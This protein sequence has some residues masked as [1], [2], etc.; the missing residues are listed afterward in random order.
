[1]EHTREEICTQVEV[2]AARLQVCIDSYYNPEYPHMTP[3]RIEVQYGKKNAKIISRATFGSSASVH[4]FV[5][6]TNGN[7]LKA[8]SFK[9][10]APNGVR[11]NIFN[12]NSDV[13]ITIGRYGAE[14]IK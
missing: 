7:I 3:N 1:M 14:Y 8:A 5:D 4:T 6:L 11:G 12:P 2:Y 13:G 10:P 9:A